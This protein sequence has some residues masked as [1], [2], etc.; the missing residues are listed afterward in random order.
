MSLFSVCIYS[1][2]CGAQCQ[3]FYRR[4]PGSG[5]LVT[6]SLICGAEN[7]NATIETLIGYIPAKKDSVDALAVRVAALE[8]LI[9]N[10]KTV[11]PIPVDPQPLVV[12]NAPCTVISCLDE[13]HIVLLLVLPGQSGDI[14]C[15][16]CSLG[17][18][19]LH[20]AQPVPLVLLA[21]DPQVNAHL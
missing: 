15:I 7:F 21:T 12:P 16:V 10:E 17:S 14:C 9:K 18:L 13:Q 2:I 6:L 5:T 19:V 1:H 8:E 4:R 11:R 20:R 3:P